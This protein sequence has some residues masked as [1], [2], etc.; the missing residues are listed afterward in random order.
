MKTLKTTN[1]N[2]FYFINNN[3]NNNLY[4]TVEDD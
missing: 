4:I 1:D 2:K 3:F